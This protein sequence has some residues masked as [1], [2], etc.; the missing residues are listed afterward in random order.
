MG[1]VCADVLLETTFSHTYRPNPETGKRRVS[2]DNKRIVLILLKRITYRLATNRFT[3][4]ISMIWLTTSCSQTEHNRTLKNLRRKSLRRTKTEPAEKG[5]QVVK[6]E[7]LETSQMQITL[8]QLPI[9]A[10]HR[11]G[12]K[13]RRAKKWNLSSK[14]L[15][16]LNLLLLTHL[17]NQTSRQ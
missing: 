14:S 9:E 10:N 5:S 12:V 3:R 6:L 11:F 15:N 2:K 4:K 16:E 13:L 8:N 1:A 17:K 7:A